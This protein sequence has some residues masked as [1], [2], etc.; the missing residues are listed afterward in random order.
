MSMI[1]SLTELVFNVYEAFTV[2]LFVKEEDSFRCLSVVTFAKSF[3]RDRRIPI[4]GT[5]PGW[6]LKHDEPLIIPNF[7]KDEATL[8]YYGADEE[9]KS[10]MAYPLEVPGVIVVDS[11][12]RYVFTDREKKLL[13]ISFGH[14]ENWRRKRGS[15]QKR[16]TRNFRL[17]AVSSAS[18]GSHALPKSSGG[19]VGRVLVISRGDLF[20]I[21]LKR[22]ENSMLLIVPGVMPASSGQRSVPVAPSLQWYWKEDRTLLPYDSG[23]LKGRPPC[24]RMTHKGAAVLWLSFSVRG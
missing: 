11:K 24:I 10:F 18:S 1:G 2:A 6:V 15:G 5:L 22:N 4:E 17:N 12:K 20:F 14:R 23:Y 19:S 9:I 21:A 8:G 7:D 3:D 13:A 16:E